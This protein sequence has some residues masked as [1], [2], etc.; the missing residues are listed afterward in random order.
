MSESKSYEPLDP[1]SEEQSSFNN[2]PDQNNNKKQIQHTTTIGTINTDVSKRASVMHNATSKKPLL[3]ETKTTESNSATLGELYQ[4]ADTVDYIM[5]F[6]GFWAAVGSGFCQ[7][8]FCLLFGTALDD[9]N[10]AGDIQ[11]KINTLCVWLVVLGIGNLITATVQT[12]C[13]GYTGERQAQKFREHYTRAVL[14]QEIGWFD[15][16]GANQ[17][18]TKLADLTGQL[19][20]GMTYKTADFIQYSSQV[21]GAVVVGLALD[22]YV[23]LIMFACTPLI[24]GTATVWVGAIADAT[25]GSAELY[26][27]A[28]GLAT[29]SLTN[30]RTVTALNAQPDVISNYR[31]FLLNVMEIGIQKGLR[32]G[33]ATGLLWFVVLCTYAITLWY[34]SIQIADTIEYGYTDYPRAQTGGKVYAAFFACLMGAFGIGQ[35]APP[36]AAFTSAR[37]AAKSFLEIIRREPLIDGLS[38]EGE[39]PEQRPTGEVELN[40]VVF[41]YPSRPEITVCKGYN[42]KILPGESCALVGASGSGKSTVI[43]LLLRFYDPNSGVVRLDGRN[44]KELN[45]RWLRAQIG[46]VGQE[47]VLFSGSIAD[48]IAY[49]LDA[50]FAPELAVIDSATA[51]PSEIDRARQI[52]RERVIEAATQAN[53]HAFIAALPQ[54]YETDVGGSGSSM[55]GGQKQRIAIARA[56]IK[57]PAVLL[58][59]EATSALDAVSEKI[60]QESIDKLQKS[61]T[62]TTIIIAHRYVFL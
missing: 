58:L 57:K 41:A 47:P 2:N 39:K 42:L 8:A 44:I 13:W 24:G 50:T 30:I 20:D 29:E 34:G 55:S 49:G 56:L 18:A 23:A 15:S 51:S 59:D 35:I 46:Y 10:S 9:L 28:G 62:Q 52:L 1:S 53:A 19:R 11:T 14:R 12:G 32:V 4:Y 43:N 37:V 6:I 33:M 5:M 16:V 54:G 26:A 38:L 40:D 61:K 25:K 22:P 60:V 31:K 36:V 21:I 48:N 27:Q 3:P 17:L 7:P 45:T